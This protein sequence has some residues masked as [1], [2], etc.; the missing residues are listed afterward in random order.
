M[1]IVVE[2][3]PDLALRTMEEHR[4]GRRAAEECMPD[5]LV[6]GSEHVFLKR[7]QRCYWMHGEVPLVLTEGAQRI[8]R[9]CASVII[10]EAAH[11]V[12]DGEVWTRGRYRIAAVF[13]PAD[14]AI[15]FEG[16]ER[17]AIA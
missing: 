9:P 16:H 13:D 8:S 6:A 3:N 7:G 1:G 17:T 5:P 4:A 12:R 14:P 2:Y 11:V 10:L 15:H